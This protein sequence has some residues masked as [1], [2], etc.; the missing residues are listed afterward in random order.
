MPRRVARR[1][2]FILTRFRKASLNSAAIVA[3][4]DGPPKRGP[5]LVR[6]VFSRCL[7]WIALAALAAGGSASQAHADLPYEVSI[8]VKG[9]SELEETLRSASLLVAQCERPPP[10]EL[11]LRRRV[12][13][14]SEQLRQ[15]I[16]AEGYYAATLDARLDLERQPAE[17]KI[18]VDPGPRYH[19]NQVSLISPD[20]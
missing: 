2:L 4:R 11:A 14:D 8:T 17:I 5:R 16:R 19:L 13:Q 15:V 7:L 20:G 1:A 10:T 9:D 6:H 3:V 18:E 12:D